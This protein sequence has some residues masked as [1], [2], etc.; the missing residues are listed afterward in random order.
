MNLA[1]ITVEI[2]SARLEFRRENR[3]HWHRKRGTDTVRYYALDDATERR[4]GEIAEHLA[5]LHATRG[6]L[7]V[8]ELTER[9]SGRRSAT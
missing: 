8:K 2:E 7:V 9:D 6:I 1:S 3:K 4:I 5:K